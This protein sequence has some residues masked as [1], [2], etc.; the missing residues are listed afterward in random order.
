MA[1]SPREF[2][3]TRWQLSLH[4][5]FKELGYLPTRNLFAPFV[6]KKIAVMM[7]LLGGFGVSAILH[8]YI[9]IGLFDI[10]TG[11]EF[12]FFMIHGVIF[13]LW[14]VAFGY[15]NKNEN[16]K[17]KRFL[18]W[19]LLAGIYSLTLPAFIEPLRSIKLIS[20]FA[21]YYMN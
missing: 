18:K 19:V 4:E 3:S 16:V 20:F 11:E 2:W 21:N 6:P 9:V 7:G 13:I 5:I 15:E 17:I 12:F 10:W 14:E 1:S 8:E